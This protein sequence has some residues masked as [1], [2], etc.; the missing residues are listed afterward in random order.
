MQ[1]KGAVVTVFLGALLGVFSASLSK[2]LRYQAPDEC[3]WVELKEVEQGVALTCRL[4]TI[5]SE[6]EN[7]NFSA[8][9]SQHTIKLRLLCNDALLYQS[10]L[11]PGSFRPLNELRELAI[12][13]CKI[14]NLSA[15]AF[16]GLHDLRNLTIKTHNTD[17]LP[18]SLEIDSKAFSEELSLLERLD[19]SSNNIWN[20]PDGVLCPLHKLLFLNLT[21]NRVRNI[22]GFQFGGTVASQR[23]GGNL[24]VLDLSNNS[25]DSL[26][27]SALS[28]LSRLEHLNLESNAISLVAERALE[29]LSSLIVLNLADNK[30]VTLPPELFSDSRRLKKLKLNNNS[31][32][33]LAP[34]LF[35]ELKELVVL[36]LSSNELTAEWV[37]AATFAGLRHLVMLDLSHNRINKL[38]PTIFRDLH[39]LQILRL[40]D[41]AIATIPENSF[42]SLSNVHTLLLSDNKLSAIQSH[43]FK[44]LGLLSLLS[45]ENN[46]IETI[47]PDALQ[48]ATGLEELHLNGNK[49][50]EVPAALKDTP[51]LKTL[52][53]GDNHIA[54]L[55]NTTF[56]NLP[57]VYGLRLTENNIV[58]ITRGVF[59]KMT[60]L[61]ILNLSYNKIRNV[62]AGSF[63]SNVNL[64]AIRLDGNYI[65]DIQKVFQKLTN[66]QWLNISDNQIEK[67]D[68][69]YIPTGLKW[70]DIH[71]NL[72]T[73]LNNHFEIE[74]TLSLNTFDAS[75]NR[76]TEITRSAI[77]DSVEVLSLSDN[78]IS[79]VQ[80]YTF[81][82]KNN[83]TRVDLFGN[84]ITSLEP[85]SL[86]ISPEPNKTLPEFYI[87]GNPYEC[88]CRMDWLQNVNSDNR[89]RNQPKLMDLDSIYCKLLFSRGRPYVPLV[90]AT[91]SQFLCSYDFHC[92][93]T[94]HCCDFDACDCEMTCP[95]NCTCYHDQQWSAN[96]VDCSHAGY[97]NSLP[98]QIPMDATQL[99]LDGNV[100][101]TIGSHAFIGRKKLTMLFLNGSSI[102]IIHNRTFNGLKKLELLHLEDNQIN[103]LK[104]YE[105]EG[106][107]SLRELYLQNNKI[108]SIHNAT[109]QYLSSLRILRLDHNSISQFAVWEL[110]G[111]I[112]S[113]SL[114]SNPWSCDCE[115]TRRFREWL[116]ITE[117][118]VTDMSAVRCSYNAP[119]S[120]NG[121][122]LVL[123]D[124]REDGFYIMYDNS[125]NCVSRMDNY[126]L[127]ESVN[128][129]LTAN[130]NVIQRQ[131]IQDYMPLLVATL[132]AFVVVILLT[133]VVFIYRQEMRVWFHSRFGVRL[134][135]RK[136][137]LEMDDREKL[138]DAFISYSSKDEAFVAE[139]L[140]PLLEHG[141]P[142]YKL[143]LHYRDFPV[144]A[145]IADT[146]VQA[147]E[148]SRRTIM[149]L[150]ENFIKSEWCRFE[151]K[152]AHHQVLR[153]RRRRLIVVLLGEVPQKDLDPDIRLYLKTNTYLQ[154]GDKLF[155]EKLRFALPDVP[156]NQRTRGG[157]GR[158]L[159]TNHYHHH[160]HRH[161]PHIPPH[162]THNMHNVHTPLNTQN[163]R[164]NGTQN[165]SQH[166][167]SVAIHI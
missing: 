158:H 33:V 9:Q 113:L 17:W 76:I 74:N 160:V 36:D 130:K 59:D 87:G 13:Y 18:M 100:I 60:S 5:N 86:R 96:V 83:L 81:F 15:G 94:C 111:S 41:N 28:G 24:K 145:F 153:D 26:P 85:N 19:L 57:Q 47:H 70:L 148:S 137:D 40:E 140:A 69:S 123:Q 20:I 16:S 117:A 68:Y 147:V 52:D 90:E 7:T 53:L 72:I 61:K 55:D 62:E 3:S 154:W 11:T 50:Y 129:N 142:S 64:H 126:N 104:G 127:T 84:R 29:G 65:K 43:T 128:G 119:V 67:F 10:S 75:S 45:L 149:V 8:I 54:Y 125:S 12:E 144:G 116:Q 133:L 27:A 25:I 42:S 106:L 131:E 101:K 31:I 163:T 51:N 159:N 1:P 110:S 73:V 122:E 34:G 88:D 132:G 134:F 121:T 78:L 152:S 103:E 98:G 118:V 2:A 49:L 157:H 112:M 39:L 114:A 155:W 135:Y 143:C 120:S 23:C 48:N 30:L 115:Y 21:Q 107:E 14:G 164:N 150:S 32:N 80:S 91:P 89:A 124:G 141:D 6:L 146:I 108:T 71:A 22:A 63:D 139:E 136:G 95:T 35:N 102:E 37:N 38:E 4:R 44:G 109:F 105:F 58:N 162:I 97:E 151:F 77:P 99:Y 138:F 161:N 79:K 166:T 82:K 165:N 92:W 93:K 66:L 56:A 46:D 156:N 167:R